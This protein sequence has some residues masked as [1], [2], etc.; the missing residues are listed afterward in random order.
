MAAAPAKVARLACCKETT[1]KS[2]SIEEKFKKSDNVTK[3]QLEDRISF[4]IITTSRLLQNTLHIPQFA[5]NSDIYGAYLVQ[6]AVYAALFICCTAMVRKINFVSQHILQHLKSSLFWNEMVSVII[7][8][9]ALQNSTSHNYRH[10]TL[11]SE[12]WLDV[13]SILDNTDYVIT[14]P[15]VS[16]SF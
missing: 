16:I 5:C 8:R 15:T 3:R 7:W 9:I 4:S 12:L 2:I 11:I 1:M 14:A 10:L 13:V 6:S